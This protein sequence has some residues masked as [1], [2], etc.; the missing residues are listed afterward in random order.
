MR[1]LSS[2]PSILIL[3]FKFPR[4][5]CLKD[6]IILIIKFRFYLLKLRIYGCLWCHY[7]LVRYFHRS[8]CLCRLCI[9]FIGIRNICIQYLIPNSSGCLRLAT[10][11][12]DI[13]P[14]LAT[15]GWL[16]LTRQA[17]HLLGYS[18]LSG[19]TIPIYKFILPHISYKS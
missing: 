14:R 4:Y 16:D 1:G 6:K 10:A 3:F 19:C 12:T 11:I 8:N 2:C 7:R 17:F 18:P 9:C 5:F 13:H 15:G